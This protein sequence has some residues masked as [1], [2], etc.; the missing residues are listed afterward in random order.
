MATENKG[1]VSQQTQVPVN[2]APAQTQS[3]AGSDNKDVVT[4]KQRARS[5]S[6]D[7]KRSRSPRKSSRSRSRGRS[8]SRSPRKG[9]VEQC[10]LYIGNISF[11]SSERDMRD[12][13]SKYGKVADVLIPEDRQTGRQRGFC[14]VS[15]ENERDADDALKN[16][17][18]RE[19]D[20]RAIRVSKARQMPAGGGSGGGPRGP[21][22]GERPPSNGGKEGC[23]D[24]ARGNCSR[25]D[26][27]RY[28]HGGGVDGG[29]SY[30]D[31]QAPRYDDNRGP[32]GYDQ[33][34]GGPGGYDQRG[35]PGGFDDRYRDDGR[36][37]Y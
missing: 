35:P 27:C 34:G 19:I 9:D 8:R 28:D 7:R 16:M 20:G 21:P 26:R 32:G 3:T 24:F 36:G 6:P 37:R 14:F 10:K 5:R 4:D 11:R 31:R 15:F 25:G 29:K 18:G 22:R 17:D 12:A 2:N 1:E 33:R 23:R 30:D 13:F